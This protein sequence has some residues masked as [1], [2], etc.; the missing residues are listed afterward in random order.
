MPDRPRIHR[1]PKTEHAEEVGRSLE[2]TAR[3]IE[4]LRQ[5]PKPDTF[6][7]RKTQEAFPKEEDR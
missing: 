3:S 2:L 1:P 5:N 7:G 6:L 4:I